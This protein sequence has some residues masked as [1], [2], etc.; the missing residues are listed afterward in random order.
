V[1]RQTQPIFLISGYTA[2]GKTTH[3]QLLAA[4]LGYE[5][6]GASAVRRALLYS[7]HEELVSEWNP[8]IDLRRQRTLAA[9]RQL[10]NIVT[11]RIEASIDPLVVDAWLQPWLCAD[12]RAIRIWLESTIESR[13]WKA[14]VTFLR[15]GLAV[16]SDLEMQVIK[17]DQFS[18]WMFSK[19]YEIE[20]RPDPKLFD[21]ILDNSSY[22][23]AP[24][25]EASDFGIAKFESLLEQAVE[26][27][28][29]RK[30]TSL[31]IA[32]CA[33]LKQE[34]RTLDGMTSP[35]G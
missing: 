32:S 8:G 1:V 11:R 15:D 7:A 22:I 23:E 9:D 25:V 24:T 4:R 29:S 35:Y 6:L 34:Q 17:K 13:I 31:N 19:L 27:V 28:C 21:L 18:R 33:P 30:K 3:A 26:E 2:A 16:P 14:I 5:Y 10:D 20:F 12:E